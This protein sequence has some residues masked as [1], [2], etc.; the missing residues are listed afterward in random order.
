MKMLRHLNV[1]KFFGQR[2]QGST[3]YLLLE[4]ADG[5][6][7]FDRI[8]TSIASVFGSCEPNSNLIIYVNSQPSTNDDLSSPSAAFSRAILY[9]EAT[10]QI[11]KVAQVYER[12]H[13][14]ESARPLY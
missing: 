12:M 1:V 10:A 6:E 13:Y 5:G 3:H 7:L 14:D 2:T 11:I 9:Y 4:Y 8:G